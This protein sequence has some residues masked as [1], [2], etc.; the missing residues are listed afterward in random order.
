MLQGQYKCYKMQ[1]L[2]L[3]NSSAPQAL[4]FGDSSVVNKQEIRHPFLLTDL[5]NLPRNNTKVLN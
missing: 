5:G 4:D 1:L 2:L 3:K